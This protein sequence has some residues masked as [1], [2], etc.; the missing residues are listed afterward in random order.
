MDENRPNVGSVADEQLEALD[1]VAHLLDVIGADHWLFG[2]WAVDFYAGAVTRHHD[3]LDLAVWLDDFPRIAAKLGDDGWSHQPSPD[4]DGGTAFVRDCVRLELTY[5][6]RGE[7]AEVYTPLREGR[8][9]WPEDALGNDVRE[10][11]GVRMRVVSLTALTRSKASARD[12][13]VE[14]AKDKADAQT[15]ARLVTSAIALMTLLVAGCGGGGEH[16][17]KVDPRPRVEASLRH[18]F[19]TFRPEDSIFPTGAGPPR[20]RSND[21][22]DLHGKRLLLPPRS[23]RLKKAEK[24]VAL[25]ECYVRFKSFTLRV[26]VGVNDRTEVI[27]AMPVYGDGRKAPELSPARTY[28]G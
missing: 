16:R 28:T 12:E 2:G 18:Y 22:K 23:T 26:Q 13:P 17:A 3:D 14:A 6:V 7:G 19:S 20:V 5:L 27:W 10:L 1:R 11:S 4:E 8:G 15:L 9:R 21:C 24:K 25:W